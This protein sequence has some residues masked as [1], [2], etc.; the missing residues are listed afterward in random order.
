[1]RV[2]DLRELQGSH[3]EYLHPLQNSRTQAQSAQIWPKETSIT[4]ISPSS[5][6]ELLFKIKHH[7]ICNKIQVID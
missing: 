1:M 5:S 2:E 6:L 7:C 3:L 4:S